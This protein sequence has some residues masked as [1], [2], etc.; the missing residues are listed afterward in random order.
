MIEV[1]QGH[2]LNQRLEE[3]IRVS[4]KQLILISPYIRLH[5]RNVD[6]LNTLK[7]RP[8]VEV[9]VCFGK[10]DGKYEKSFHPDALSLL[11]EL[12]NITIVYEER[13]HAKFYANER[14]SLFTSMNLYDFSADNNI[15]VGVYASDDSRA[16]RSLASEGLK[17]FKEVISNAVKV[18][19]RTPSFEKNILGVFG[20]K[21]AG[22]TTNL[23]VLQTPPEESKFTRAEK[24]VVNPS[25]ESDNQEKQEVCETK[26]D[27]VLE[28]LMGYC[29]RSGTPIPF[30][31]EEP[32]TPK[33]FKSW[34]RFED[35]D[36]EEKFCHFSGE[37]S[38]GRTSM[39][40]PIMKKNWKKAVKAWETAT[41]SATL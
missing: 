6:A 37:E 39:A 10:A 15:E 3:V 12:P 9:T 16:G 17:Y 2:L 31:I 18:Y 22:S 35:S 38:K 4:E 8:E 24:A 34:A 40:K 25:F 36:Y 32:M 26:K 41:G 28:P 1:V 33:A 20:R 21:Y 29:I 14:A 7:Q 23:D 27:P 11:K 13:L 5:H 19:E 30:N